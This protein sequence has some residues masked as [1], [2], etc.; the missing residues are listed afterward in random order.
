MLARKETRKI[1][2]DTISR[3]V[4]EFGLKDNH[5][6]ACGF[7]YDKKGK[8]IYGGQCIDTMVAIANADKIDDKDFRNLLYKVAQ[9]WKLYHCNDMHAG[10]PE[11]EKALRDAG[12]SEFAN[13]YNECCEYLEKIGLLE[14]RGY[15]FGTGWLTWDIPADV[16][17]DM[18]Q[19]IEA[20]K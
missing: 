8:C 4:L 15:K 7:V 16:L 13:K 3:M 5:F 1:N 6:S 17:E 11:Q 19:T 12:L 20:T 10:T 14:V 2:S 18:K 9:W